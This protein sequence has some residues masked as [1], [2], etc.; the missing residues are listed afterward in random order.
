MQYSFF[1]HIK[2]FLLLA[3]MLLMASCTNKSVEIHVRNASPQVEFAVSE[4]AKNIENKSLIKNEESEFAL[5]SEALNIV[6]TTLSDTVAIQY[7]IQGGGSIPKLYEQGYHLFTIEQPKKV[8]WVIGADNNGAMY[9]GLQL[10]EYIK[11]Y[12]VEKS[13]NETK[14][15][16]IKR[17]G[18]KINIPLD[19]RAPSYDDE[20]DAARSNIKHMW[21]FDFW[22]EYIDALTRNNYNVLSLWNCHPFN[23]M[24]K[25][26]GYP[27]VA[28]EDVHD[29]NGL[30]KKIS[31][32]EKIEFWTQVFN[33]AKDRGF[34]IFW[35]NWNVFGYG[36]IGKYGIEEHPDNEAFT[37]YSRKALYHF[38]KT[39]PQID[40]FGVSAG[41]NFKGLASIE[42]EAWMRKTWGAAVED[43]KRDYPERDIFFI[44][45]YLMSGTDPIMAH[46]SDLKVH[47]DFSFK[48]IVGHMYGH[49]APTLIWDKG[50]IRDIEE[51][52]MK[53]WLNIRN[54]DMFYFRWGDIS[55]ARNYIYNFPDKDKYLQG[56]YLG[57]DGYVFG[58]TFTFKE[59]FSELNDKLE[60]DKHWFNFMLF[61]KLGYDPEIPDSYFIDQL[62]H[63][64]SET[65]AQL[66]Y[67]AWQTASQIV[68]SVTAANWSQNDDS[69]Y[70]EGCFS[71]RGIVNLA[72]FSRR[73]PQNGAPIY[74]ISEY[75][76][77]LEKGLPMELQTPPETAKQLRDLSDKALELLPKIERSENKELKS[78]LLDIEA[79][80]RLGYYYAHKFEGAV[81][82]QQKEYEAAT[83]KMQE[84]KEL[85]T[86]YTNTV[87][88]QYINQHLSRMNFA[89]NHA[90]KDSSD[91]W[92]SWEESIQRCDYDIEL[93][94]NKPRIAII[95]KADNK[96]PSGA[97]I[98][99]L[100]QN[101]K[102]NIKAEVTTAAHVDLLYYEMLQNDPRPLHIILEGNA[103]HLTQ[104]LAELDN[105]Y[106]NK[107]RER[108]HANMCVLVKNKTRYSA[109]QEKYPLLNWV[110]C[111]DYLGEIE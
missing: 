106:W 64:F 1:N 39:Y 48:Y 23:A 110:E 111:D 11:L 21:D 61:G 43:I 66:L 93:A 53:T 35:F 27:D 68:P 69:W 52:N 60:I 80:A 31:I 42:R 88:S 85:W 50:I 4:L 65:N 32:D 105:Y 76:N 100:Q 95:K 67:E 74:S 14:N 86:E 87:S 20:G 96:A 47:M 84:A 2:L 49:V 54:D 25:I 102:F 38:L 7:F 55:Y 30:V 28:I 44:H 13:H 34:K 97:L 12:G 107:F 83:L 89:K 16:Y 36:A 81:L 58:K 70:I 101:E 99:V 62:Q 6:I 108:I 10:A 71:N 73:T 103:N 57:T 51:R 98:K 41:E 77:R 17:R 3:V 40:A 104:A 5:I 9:G 19:K 79:F 94:I 46:F 91:N 59:H 29:Y 33:Y 8:H 22:T 24:C 15:P 45:R 72:T 109:L 90:R 78:L 63:R 75:V 26:P 18:I 82:Y 56:Y 37:E 92:F